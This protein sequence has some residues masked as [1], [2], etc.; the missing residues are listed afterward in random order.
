MSTSEYVYLNGEW[1]APEEAR[2]SVSD[3]GFLFADAIY[4]AS[5]AYRGRFLRLEAHMA[6]LARGLA[7]LRIEVD[8]ATIESLHH[9]ILRRNALLEASWAMVYVQI[10][11][12]AAPR[13]HAFPKQPVPPTVY[14]F[15]RQLAAV[16]D[17]RWQAGYSAITHID[18]RWAGA[19][20]KTTM[21]LPNVLAQQ[22][23]VEAGADDVI[24]L[25]D[26]IAIEG[27]H[28][29]LF[30]VKNGVLCTA[31]LDHRVLAGITRSIVI[32][33]AG[34]LGLPV[35]EEDNSEA[36]LKDADEV[37]LCGTTTEIRPIVR[38][39]DSA[40]ADGRVGPITTRLA[41]AF[42]ALTRSLEQRTTG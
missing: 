3:R 35:R 8:T 26:G 27:S 31:P 41:E 14:L 2:V 6:R 11:R 10:S 29:N 20:L 36:A 7:A 23:A 40:V 32:D 34:E 33:L 28:A 5:P 24:L 25:K 37:F 38:I 15:A 19:D 17:S 1:C 13:A 22:A 9:E 39:D 16:D 30:L 42:E 4:E 18:R 12:G 21:L